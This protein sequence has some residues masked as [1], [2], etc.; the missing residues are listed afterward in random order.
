[1]VRPYMSTRDNAL[2]VLLLVVDGFMSAAF[3]AASPETVVLQTRFQ[4][5]SATFFLRFKNSTHYTTGW[6]DSSTFH[7]DVADAS[8]EDLVADRSVQSALVS[9]YSS[10]NYLA[11]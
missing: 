1:M 6:R 7:I 10:G 8:V 11:G 9:K 3:G 4:P 2:C 5:Q